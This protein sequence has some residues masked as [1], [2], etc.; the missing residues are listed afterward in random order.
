MGPEDTK[1]R[2]PKHASD[3]RDGEIIQTDLTTRNAKS[4]KT[5]EVLLF[6][7]ASLRSLRVNQVFDAIFL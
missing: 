3:H 7:P 2:K 5:R 6:L 1:H 4:T